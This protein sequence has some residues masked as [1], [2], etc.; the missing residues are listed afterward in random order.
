MSKSSPQR[1]KKQ[2]IQM[3]VFA[4]ISISLPLLVLAWIA[5]FNAIQSSLNNKIRED[6]TLS[7]ELE[8]DI[9]ENEKS[10]LL[11]KIKENKAIKKIR[12]INADLALKELEEEI[13]E[14]P[15]AILG[16]NPL[17]PY[18]E[19]NLNS[20]YTSPDKIIK[21]KDYISNLANVQKLTYRAELFYSIDKKMSSVSLGLLIFALLLFIIAI[22][23]I[24]NTTQL[25]IYSKR[26]LIRSMSLLGANRSFI[27][28]PFISYSIINGII[29]AVL[30][31]ILLLASIFL[32]EQF[33]HFQILTH[34]S[35][36]Q[37]ILILLGILI[38]SILLSAIVAFLAT[39]RYIRMDLERITLI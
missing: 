12:Y 17:T 27:C 31:F 18:I 1:S 26:Q 14:D 7:I 6:L 39:K 9:T 33:A 35:Q 21:V 15:I 38:L 32:C 28:R 23:Q 36:I 11:K 37:I 22:I 34:I 16:Y 8:K 13:E 25:M 10:L 24:S 30:A 2:P 3:R 20:E 5:C 29:G 19:V 4:I